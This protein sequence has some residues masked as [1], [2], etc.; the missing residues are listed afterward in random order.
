M[1]LMIMNEDDGTRTR[2]HRID[3]LNLAGSNPKSVNDF[4][5]SETP[6]RSAGRSD[7]TGEGGPPADPDLAALIAAWPT[8]PPHIRAAVQAL[9]ATT[10]PASVT[11]PSGGG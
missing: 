11:G 7:T 5:T 9:V 10:R 2:N 8:L 3:S 1:S 4:D 6:G